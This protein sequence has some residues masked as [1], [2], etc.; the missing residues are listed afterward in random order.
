MFD[1]RF[2]DTM[3]AFMVIAIILALAAAILS[4]VFILPRKKDGHFPNKFLQFLHDLFHF[5]RLLIE[6]ITKFLYI[7]ATAFV[8]VFG[9]LT[10]FSAPLFGLLLMVLGPIVVRIIY[11]FMMLT[12]LLVQN[13]IDINRKIKG[14]IA[15]PRAEAPSFQNYQ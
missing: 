6:Q 9:F 11:E 15:E 7:F 12:I 5:K 4:F 14:N 2:Y 3:G 13:V 10:L 1:Y 8:I